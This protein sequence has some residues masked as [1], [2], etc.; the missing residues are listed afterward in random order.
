MITTYIR[1]TPLI[2]LCSNY[3]YVVNECFGESITCD[4]VTETHTHACSSSQGPASFYV[5]R[6]VACAFCVY[7]EL[8][9]GY[10]HTAFKPPSFSVYKGS[11]HHCQENRR[12]RREQQRLSRKCQRFLFQNGK[13]IQQ[14]LKEDKSFSAIF[15]QTNHHFSLPGKCF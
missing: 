11:Y 3:S 12:E 1:G 5:F 15:L 10:T 7:L 4:V 2:I 13:S 9:S 8:S 6:V 14:R